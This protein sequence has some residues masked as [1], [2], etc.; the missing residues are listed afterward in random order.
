MIV[1]IC[2]ILLIL[3]PACSDGASTAGA[4]AGNRGATADAGAFSDAGGGAGGA[5]GGPA[6]FSDAGAFDAGGMSPD[7]EDFS[8][9]GCFNGLDDDANELTD[10]ADVVCGATA[11]CCVG[12]SSA[13]CCSGSGVTLAADFASC[14]GADPRTCSTETLDWFGTPRPTIEAERFLPNGDNLDDSGIVLG[15]PVDPTRERVTLSGVIAAPLDGC[16]DCLDVVTLGLADRPSTDDVRVVADVALMVRASRR[17]YALIVAGEAVW[18]APLVDDAPHGYQLEVT[19]DGAAVL[20]VDGVVAARSNVT[21]RA[22]RTPLL[23]GRTHNRDGLTA[24]ARVAEVSVR[25]FGCDIPAAIDRDPTAAIPFG[26]V[27]W[28]GALASDPSAILDGDERLVAFALERDIHLARRSADGTWSLAGS[29]IVD[30]PALVAATGESLSAPELIREE[31][32][33]VL[34]VTRETDASTSILRADGEPGHAE[35]F[36]PLTTLE[37]PA[38][39]ETAQAPSVIDMG[40]ARFMAIRTSFGGASAIAL[41]QA[42]DTS[43]ASFAWVNGSRARSIVVTPDPDFERFDHDEVSDPDL[44]VDAF[45]L[46]RLYYA[47]RRG[48]RWSIGMRVSGDRATWR[49]PSAS[50][51]LTGSGEGHDSLWTRHPSVLNTPAGTELFYTASDGVTMDIGR[52]VGSSR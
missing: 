50:A 40:A 6:A 22:N 14:G 17:D 52:A 35:R 41:L 37:L 11:Y 28:G 1:R 51:L 8:A 10:C 13:A 7:A 39:A 44:L 34:Y 31:D 15:E 3:L 33:F 26:G 2:P 12:S 27:P 30:M 46:V 24:N 18:S 20:S 43:G 23:F 16:T 9:G 36:G 32:R 48:T 47:G 21:L 19:P 5:D 38:D 42:T 25:S 29:G 4:D 45:G 49:E